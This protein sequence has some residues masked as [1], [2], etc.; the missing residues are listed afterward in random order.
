MNRALSAAT[1]LLEQIRSLDLSFGLSSDEWIKL[2]REEI[3]KLSRESP[4][5]FARIY[6]KKN[7]VKCFLA[8]SIFSREFRVSHQ[9]VDLG[10]GPGTFLF[11]FQHRLRNNSFVGIDR[12]RDSLAIAENIFKQ[13]RLPV[14]LLIRGDLPYDLVSG[15]KMFT[16]SYLLAELDGSEL[17][18]MAALVG[19]RTDASFLIVD[20]PSVID[21]FCRATSSV[22]KIKWRWIGVELPRSLA[23]LV[24]DDHVSFGVAFAERRNPSDNIKIPR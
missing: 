17:R 11:P 18:A 23:E 20:Y 8:A 24:G 3:S 13:L 5:E 7:I 22:R 9:V 19:R 21:R 2:P 6:L 14:P 10:T 16:A 1:P 4:A 12:N 15:G